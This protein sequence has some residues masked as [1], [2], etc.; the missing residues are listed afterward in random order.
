VVVTVS[1]RETVCVVTSPEIVVAVEAVPGVVTEES[2]GGAIGESATTVVVVALVL[3]GQATIRVLERQA[4]LRRG[5]TTF[6]ALLHL[7][8]EIE[9]LA[10]ERERLRARLLAVVDRHAGDIARIIEPD[11]HGDRPWFDDDD[12]A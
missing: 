1:V 3:S 4:D 8:R 11:E 7:D 12:A 10:A 9:R 2:A 5:F 6:V